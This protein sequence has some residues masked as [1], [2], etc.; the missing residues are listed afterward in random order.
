[1]TSGSSC[2][3][4]PKTGSLLREL[5]ATAPS[6]LFLVL[7]E[8][9]F[10]QKFFFPHHHLVNFFI[11]FFFF[12]GSCPAALIRMTRPPPEG[13]FISGP[14]GIQKKRPFNFSIVVLLS[15]ADFFSCFS[16]NGCYLLTPVPRW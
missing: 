14:F 9:L 8:I 4:F 13:Y 16:S 5:T 11:D 15:V 10:F 6:G 2:E 7:L 12:C 1:L 3:F